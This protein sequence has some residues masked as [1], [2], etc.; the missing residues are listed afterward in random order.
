[1]EAMAAHN[2]GC[3]ALFP[4]PPQ[5]VTLPECPTG[6]PRCVI[7]NVDGTWSRATGTDRLV[8]KENL[9]DFP[10]LIDVLTPFGMRYVV[11]AGSNDGFSTWLF[12]RAWSNATVLAIEPSLDNYGMTSLN[13]RSLPNVRAVRAALWNNSSRQL[14]LAGQRMGDWAIMALEPGSVRGRQ[15]PVMEMTPTVELGSLMRAACFPRLDF[16]KM[17]VE[18]AEKHVLADNPNWLR[19]VRFFQA[20]FHPNDL[21]FLPAVLGALL[22]ANM[23]VLTNPTLQHPT[24]RGVRE[25]V[26]FGCGHS[27]ASF[28]CLDVCTKWRSG[29]G[30]HCTVVLHPTD[31]WGTP[32]R[33]SDCSLRAPSVRD[34]LTACLVTA[35]DNTTSQTAVEDTALQ[36]CSLLIVASVSNR[37]NITLHDR[38]LRKFGP[39]WKCVMLTYSERTDFPERCDVIRHYNTFWGQILH[40]SLGQISNYGCG[41]KLLMLDDVDI[42]DLDVPRLQ[43]FA[44]Q[45]RLDVASPTVLGATQQLMRFTKDGRSLETEHQSRNNTE[46]DAYEARLSSLPR[47]QFVELYATLLSPLAWLTFSKLLELM[48]NGKGW[49]YD[50]CLGRHLASGVDTSQ[51]VLHTGSRV[52]AF[53]SGRFAASLRRERD[54]LSRT[55]TMEWFKRIQPAALMAAAAS[56]SNAKS[57]SKDSLPT[58]ALADA[59]LTR[60]VVTPGQTVPKV[61]TRGAHGTFERYESSDMELTWLTGDIA[62][63]NKLCEHAK[64][65]AI[66]AAAQ[67]WV[68]FTSHIAMW[69]PAGRPAPSPTQHQDKVLSHFLVQGH[70]EPIEPLHGVARHPFG[71]P[72]C[73]KNATGHSTGLYDIT[74]L[75]LHNDCSHQKGINGCCQSFGPRPQGCVCLPKPRVLLFD[76]GASSG[77]KGIPSGILTSVVEGGDLSPSLP[78]FWKLYKDRCLEPDAVFCWETELAGKRRRRAAVTHS[79]WWGNLGPELRHKVRFFE[80]PV[81]EGELHEAM[82]GIHNPNSFLQMLQSVARPEDF[83]AVKLDIDTPAIE[84]TIIGTLTQRPDLAALIDELFFEYHFHFDAN[85]DFGWGDVPESISV[86][87][88]LATMHRLRELGIRAHFWI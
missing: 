54:E 22:R 46:A 85:I 6:K 45:H 37:T 42:L 72:A 48:P 73:A 64:K 33:R 84:Q 53:A 38:N 68:N 81:M 41:T 47:G 61:T 32:H 2:S 11:D 10:K 26:F 80:V 83:V 40:M 28:D 27:V 78:L 3:V 14:Q 62:K 58:E 88:A 55:C 39:E 29:T 31:Y 63:G 59:E 19:S 35:A 30:L 18:G 8:H 5:F 65:P 4:E 77:F 79:E 67:T 57:A 34:A 50:K 20:E 87:A 21:L 60:W 12:A 36:N 71:V 16:L 25:W 17:D 43:T 52:L 66:V 86:D 49:G 56:T 82:A 75:L 70:M 74:Y 44:S 69:A 51:H 23:T 76:M 1:M 9:I 24:A 13:T 15:P 7:R